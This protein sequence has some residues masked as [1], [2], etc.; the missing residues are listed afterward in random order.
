[1]KK[2]SVIIPVYNNP[3]GLDTLL[4]ALVNQ[5]YP[6]QLYEIIVVDNGS[7]DSTIDVARKYQSAYKDLIQVLIEDKVRGSYTARNTGITQ[8]EGEI[9]AMI[10]S[11]CTPIPEWIE[12]GVS[13]LHTHQADLIGGGVRFV[14]PPHAGAA[15][16]YDAI[17]HLQIKHVIE[18]LGISPTAN[19]FS[20]RA[21]F[22]A[23]GLFPVNVKSRGD[24]IWT[25]KATRAGFKLLYASEAEVSHP[26]RNLR[27][28][29]EKKYRL[30]SESF[31]F[32]QS[33]GMDKSRM[34]KNVL[35]Y[36]LPPH[37]RAIGDL[38]QSRGTNDMKRHFWSI[39]LTAWLCRYVTNMGRIDALFRGE[40]V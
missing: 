29:L 37:P 40:L 5:S 32:W 27:E 17:A 19:L 33:L 6:R 34:L 14:F 30:G 35:R 1:V 22:N 9:I 20:R 38:I 7:K 28:L 36:F 39:W 21:V 15:E 16:M 4:Q 26:A 2:V 8:S 3:S 11:D 18:T 25:R 10:D 24:S 31:S 12:R 23:I 13:A